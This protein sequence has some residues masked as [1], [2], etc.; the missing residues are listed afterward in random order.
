[1]DGTRSDEGGNNG[2]TCTGNRTDA[3]LGLGRDVGKNRSVIIGAKNRTNTRLGLRK[4]VKDTGSTIMGAKN[5]TDVGSD[6]QTKKML[7]TM[8]QL[9]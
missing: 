8:N 5:K 7:E 2:I 6:F 3:R 4:D 9:V 1:M